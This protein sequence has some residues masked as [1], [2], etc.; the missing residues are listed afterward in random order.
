MAPRESV[1]MSESWAA[2]PAKKVCISSSMLATSVQMGA[3]DSNKTYLKGRARERTR[4][5]SARS[6]QISRESIRNSPKCAIFLTNDSGISAVMPRLS[7]ILFTISV[8]AELFYPD[9]APL[10]IELEKMK[11]IHAT[12]RQSRA[13]RKIFVFIISLSDFI[14]KNY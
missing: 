12:V 10:S 1:S 7:A 2:L 9:S 8:T 4:D 3:A 5:V 6:P 13:I 11:H 14:L